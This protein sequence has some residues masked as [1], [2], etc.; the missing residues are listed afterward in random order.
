[1]VLGQKKIF[2]FFCNFLYYVVPFNALFCAPSGIR[3]RN[4]TF[5]GRA[6]YPIELRGRQNIKI[7]RGGHKK[8][9]T[10]S[11]VNDRGT[12]PNLT[13]TSISRANLRSRVV[14]T[15]ST[16]FLIYI[17]LLWHAISIKN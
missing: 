14:I 15:D 13:T 6:L 8:S 1:M 2:D 17:V 5:S 3:A 10:W 16:A 11:N 12:G 4:L 7:A 9:A